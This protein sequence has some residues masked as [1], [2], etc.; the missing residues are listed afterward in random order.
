MEISNVVLS[1]PLQ[2][3]MEEHVSLRQ[4]MDQ[5]YEITEEIESKSGLVVVQLF[6]ELYERVSAFT[7]NLKAHSKREDVGLFPMMSRRLGDNDR[8]IEVME[9]EHEK[10]EGHLQDFLSEA[11]QAGSTIDEN[12][13]Q[14]IS[15]Y[16]VQAYATLTQHFAKEEKVLFPLA[17]KI[18]SVDEKEELEHLFQASEN[19]GKKYMIVQRNKPT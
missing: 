6:G 2:Q 15:V 10:A 18:L 5:F 7:I 16:A 11:E 8:T 12:T 14:W 19:L 1:A 4:A 13:A 3:L 17:E 9:E